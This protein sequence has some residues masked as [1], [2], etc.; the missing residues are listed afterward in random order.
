[1]FNM[2]L[3]AIFESV[4]KCALLRAKGIYTHRRPNHVT[5][6]D[7]VIII[8]EIDGMEIYGVYTFV[9]K[10]FRQVLRFRLP[11]ITRGN[12]FRKFSD[13]FLASLERA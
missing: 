2:P 11:R 4:Q 6:Y 12:N 3:D 1:M 13:T 8:A 5:K 9:R 7:T 10:T